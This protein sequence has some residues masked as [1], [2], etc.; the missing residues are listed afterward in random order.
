MR[1]AQ[2]TGAQAVTDLSSQF[3]LQF[4]QST[5]YALRNRNDNSYVEDLYDAILRR[6]ASP[7]EV[8][9]WAGIL[10]GGA[11]REHILQDFIG[12]VEF[13]L[14]VQQVINTGCL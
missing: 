1:I 12:S 8:T 9:Y 11:S 10:T 13:Q 6:S 2:C 14:R 3:A 5:E 4:I 7:T